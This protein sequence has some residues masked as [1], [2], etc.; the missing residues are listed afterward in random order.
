MKLIL[1]FY[2]FRM[3]SKKASLFHLVMH[4]FLFCVFFLDNFNSTLYKNMPW[5]LCSLP[6]LFLSLVQAA[7]EGSEVIGNFHFLLERQTISQL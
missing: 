1:V 7:F 3:K 2:H 4:H 5:V 6:I